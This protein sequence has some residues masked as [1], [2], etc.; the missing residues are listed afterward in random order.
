MRCFI[1]PEGASSATQNSY[2]QIIAIHAALLSNGKIVYFSGDQHDPGQFAHGAFDH[3]R[4]FDCSTF[5]ITSCTPAPSISDLFCCGHAFLPDG[6]VLIAGGTLRFDGFLGS[7]K[8]WSYDP[9]SA[10]FLNASQMNQG[11]WYPTLVTLGNG[12]VLALSGI[13]EDPNNTDQNRDI[14]VFDGSNWTVEGV[15]SYGTDTLY[16]RVHLLPDGRVFFVTSMNGQCMAW[17]QGMSTPAPLCASPFTMGFSAYTSVLLPL[18]HEDNYAPR[19]LVANIEQP[20][21]IDLSVGS[22]AWSDTNARSLPADG[23][24]TSTAPN[25]ANGTLT[26]LPTGEVLS[27]GGEQNYGDEA[28]PVLALETYRHETDSWAVM[29]S[30]TTVNRAYHSTALLMPDGRVWFAGSDKRCD[31]SLHNSGDYQNLPQ[32]TDLQEIKSGVPVD[33]RE[34]RIE[35]FEPWYFSRND[36]PTISL[37]QQNVGVGRTISFTSSQAASISRVALVRAGS[38]T[39]GFNSDQRYIGIPFTVN[40]NNVEATVPDNDNLVPP[41][42]YMVFVLAQVVDPQIGAT[43]DVPSAGHWITVTNTKFL[44]E[45]LKEI[46]P[47][48]EHIKVEIEFIPKII[49]EGGDPF[50]NI[51]DPVE[52]L[53]RIAATV[54]NLSRVVSGG[55][56]FIPPADRPM[57]PVISRG[58]LATVPIHPLD[59][60]TLAR[61]LKMEGMMDVASMQGGAEPGGG[62]APGGTSGKE[63]GG[64]VHG[65]MGKGGMDQ[66]RKDRKKR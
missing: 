39:H 48:F 10:S 63:H 20:Q 28:H 32:P 51:G 9:A 35:I 17:S 23:V 64:I 31:W 33:N 62:K 54:D 49:A 55:R 21:V 65:E 36:R 34:L 38:S 13:N 37:S 29:P 26:L 19:I 57:L 14:E 12:R 25:R 18:L 56:A 50:E 6:R 22:P 61:Q 5:A 44:K 53:Q 66:P 7:L 16:P 59:K 1:V 52:I 47:E 60:D 40:G 41:G 15:L 43:L 24:L 8:A 27:A 58:R 45:L 42:P 2:A 11:R 3:A 46:K 30:R 4:L